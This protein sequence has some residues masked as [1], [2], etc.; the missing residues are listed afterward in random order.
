MTFL[1]NFRIFPLV[2]ALITICMKSKIF[3]AKNFGYVRFGNILFDQSAIDFRPI[4]IF[5]I[6]Y[7]VHSFIFGG[8]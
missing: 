3:Y 2:L 8:P 6:S 1:A 4:L 5:T 7:G